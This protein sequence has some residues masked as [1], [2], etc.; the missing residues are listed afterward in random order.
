MIKI[1][2][3]GIEGIEFCKIDLEVIKFI[4]VAVGQR[5]DNMIDQFLKEV[6]LICL[7]VFE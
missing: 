1:I 5:I 3:N 2:E 7:D 4:N 6:K